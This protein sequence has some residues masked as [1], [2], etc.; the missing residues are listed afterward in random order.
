MRE[1]PHIAPGHA[2][3]AVD[4]EPQLANFPAAFSRT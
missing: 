3:L 4:V 2:Q 1:V